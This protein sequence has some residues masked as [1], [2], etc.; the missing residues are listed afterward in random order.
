MQLRA[1][2]I[3]PLQKVLNGQYYNILLKHTHRLCGGKIDFYLVP[4]RGV[5]I[6]FS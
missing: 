3:K 6:V 1:T 2:I 5:N 4:Q